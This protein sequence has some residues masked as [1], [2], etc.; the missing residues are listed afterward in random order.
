MLLSKRIVRAIALAPVLALLAGSALAASET[1]TAELLDA[2]PDADTRAEAVLAHA[3]EE[4]LREQGDRPVL[5][6]GTTIDETRVRGEQ[7]GYFITLPAGYLEALTPLQAQQLSDLFRGLDYNVPRIRRHVLMIRDPRDGRHYPLP[8]FLPKPV[9]A[10][11]KPREEAAGVTRQTGQPPAQGQG[12]PAGYLAGKSIFVNPGHGWY[13][14]AGSEA[15]TTQRGNLYSMIEDHSNAEAVD[16]YLIHYLWNAG[17]GVY[18]CRERDLNGNSVI[19]DNEDAG[20]VSTG[21]WVL[22]TGS[23]YAGSSLRAVASVAETASATFTPEIPADGQYHV[24]FWYDGGAVNADG[25]KITIRHAGGETVWTQN[26]KLDGYTWKYVGRYYFHAGSSPSAG[27]VTISNSSADTGFDV[28]ADAV[29]FGGG[30]GAEI[31]FG[32]PSGSGMPRWEEAGPY[33]ASYMG[34]PSAS[35]GSSTVLAMPQYAKW[36]SEAWED[37]IYVSWHSNASSGSVRG[38]SSFAYA[39]GGWDMPFDGVPGGLELRDFVHDELINDLRLAR[40]PAW[41]DVGLHTSWF[42]EINPAYNDEMPGAL[43]EMAFHDNPDDVAHLKDPTFRQTAARA[44]YQGIVRYFADRDGDP[45]Y[46]LLPE[47]PVNLRVTNDGSG[48]VTVAWEAPPYDSGDGLLGHAATGYR[49]Y[50]SLDG[51]GFGDGVEL[52][53]GATTSWVDSTVTA[54]ATYYYRVTATNAGGESFPTETLAVRVSPGAASLLVVA[55]FDRLDHFLSVV[56]I[57]PQS[58]LSVHRGDVERMNSYRYAVTYGRSIDAY[59]V[60]FDTCSN[61]AVLDGHVSLAAYDAVLWFCGEEGPTDK[62]FDAAEQSLVQS[63]LDGGGNL[64]VSGTD[65][66]WDLDFKGNGVSFYRDYLM[67]AYL[68]DDADTYDV[69]PSPAGI[70][71]GNAPFSFDDGTHG[72][73][74]GNY[75]DVIDSNGGSQVCLAYEGGTGGYA[76]IQYDGGSY[77]VVNLGFPFETITSAPAR[78]ELM[79][80]LLGF[81]GTTPPAPPPVPDGAFGSP[82]VSRRLDP[83]GTSIEL[84]WDAA[85]CPAAGYH[86][87]YGALGSVA[88]YAVD[89]SVCGLDPSGSDTWAGAPTGDLWY[90]VLSS[91]GAQVEGAWGAATAGARNGGLFSGECGTLTRDDAGVC[92]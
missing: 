7:G 36:E 42:G 52:A 69:K 12:Q 68:Q 58:G 14:N 72:E 64:L 23:G 89:G 32:E 81:F 10:P 90:L 1:D 21:S 86:L 45:A 15:W 8:H 26:Q 20:F 6:S 43:F 55:G 29:R 87:V 54:T 75:P 51:F 73:Y 85:L 83:G 33:H 13:Y 56:A 84:T 19:V 66:G 18:S 47:P 60:A 41:R 3:A 92:P 62:T 77:K 44:V 70:F 61:E 37:S 40:E 50:R 63:Y 67:A 53:G 82:L 11:P 5:P 27:S 9:P 24:S 48:A 31:P 74:D 25:V 76:G 16:T 30:T 17:A 57:D 88:S 22:D 2:A 49:V 39:S 78:D 65:V 71:A 91:D 35:C 38:T 34:C 79:A 46:T 80:D 59:G 28:V 4:V